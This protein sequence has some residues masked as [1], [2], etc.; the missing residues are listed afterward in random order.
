MAAPTADPAPITYPDSDGLPMAENTRQFRWIVTIQGNLDA[1][2]RGDPSV[3]VAG[4]NLWYPVRGRPDIRMAPDVYVV[5]GRPK[6]DRGSYRQW[7][8]GN[9]P[10]TVVF[11][12]L[13][14][15]NRDAEMIRKFRFYER[16]GVEEYYMYDPD[17]AVLTAYRRA[18][19][20]LREIDPIDGWVSPRLGIRFD[21]SS[22]SELVLYQP[23]GSRFLTFVEQTEAMYGERQRANEERRARQQAQQ[24]A[25]VEC[26]RAE[27]ERARAEQL[28]DKLR[29]LGVDPG[30]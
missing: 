22:E 13:S 27:A 5:V 24:R 6:G 7:E 11:E 3:F 20:E 1:L 9:V 25:D 16:Y 15:G 17:A 26:A 2:Y 19:D 28:A 12:V 4:D 14:P 18:D 21:T 8:E 10:L 23:D 29:S 30:G